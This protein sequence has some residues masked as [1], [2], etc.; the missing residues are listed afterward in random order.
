MLLFVLFTAPA[1]NYLTL[2]TNW[3]PTIQFNSDTKYPELVQTPQ[4]KG[5]AH[6]LPPPLMPTTNGV[7]RRLHFKRPTT[8]LGAP[9]TPLGFDKLF[10]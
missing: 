1:T 4:V 8:N 7:F 2:S 10:E 6:G 3:C 5:S 9:M